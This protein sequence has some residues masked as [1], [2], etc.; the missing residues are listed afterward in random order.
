MVF[1]REN[2]YIEEEKLVKALELTLK[3]FDDFVD[4]LISVERTL[5][6][7]VHFIVQYHIAKKPMKLFSR[8]GAIAITRSLE[9]EGIVN[10]ATI[11]SVLRLVEQYRIEQ[12][13]T[14][15][16]HSIYEHSSSLLV[17]NQ[18]HWLSYQD[19]V[20]IFRTKVSRLT[21]AMDSIRRSDNPMIFDEDTTQIE[22]VPHFS[23]SGLEKLSI[24]LSLSLRS[25]ERREYCERV[26]EVAPPVLEFLALAPSPSDSQIKRA[27]T[28]VKNQNNKCCQITG[29]TRNKYNNPRLELVAHHLYDQNN[30]RF[31]ADDPDNIIAIR[32]EISD[33]FHLWNGGFKKSCTIDDFIEY[34]EWK[35]PE[36]HDKILM[37]YNRREV[38]YQKL[39]MLQRT[40]PYGE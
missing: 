8:E 35:Y 33:D 21:S 20:K 14:K 22:G 13:D 27:K 7:S 29:A 39:K 28:F 1:S 24:E 12:I 30:Y 32:E 34:I 36:K 18:R 15:V 25:Q 10:D 2:F 38:L 19:V 3:E 31:L 9:K 26:R 4:V 37:L 17:K 16:R 23:L 40:L 5:H 11:E 6:E